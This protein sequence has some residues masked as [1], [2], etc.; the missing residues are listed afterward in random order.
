MMTHMTASMQMKVTS[1]P[2]KCVKSLMKCASVPLMTASRGWNAVLLIS[3]TMSSSST[4]LCS[5]PYHTHTL[6]MWS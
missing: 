6:Y 3:R 1:T 4:T 2:T 5:V